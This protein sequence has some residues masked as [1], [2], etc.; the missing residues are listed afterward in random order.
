ML[1]INYIHRVDRPWLELRAVLRAL[2]MFCVLSL[3]IFLVDLSLCLP[4]F[5]LSPVQLPFTAHPPLEPFTMTQRIPYMLLAFLV[6][7]IYL[8]Y[9]V[10]SQNAINPT[11][12]TQTQQAEF[13]DKHRTEHSHIRPLSLREQYEQQVKDNHIVLYTKSWCP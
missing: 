7:T 10:T 2:L 11:N 13:T 1:C 9:R 5:P 4:C 6:G 12:T 3:V 8:V